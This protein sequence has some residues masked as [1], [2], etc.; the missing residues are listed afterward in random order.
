MFH[1]PEGGAFV[2]LNDLMCPKNIVDDI[3][4]NVSMES[5]DKRPS[6]ERLINFSIGKFDNPSENGFLTI[7]CEIPDLIIDISKSL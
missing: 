6:K 2:I 1:P 3:P 4:T 5:W 7:D